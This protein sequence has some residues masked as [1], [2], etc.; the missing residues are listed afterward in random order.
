MKRALA[1]TALAL[2]GLAPA[3]GAAC[4]Y[5]DAS[6]ASASEQLGMAPVPPASKAPAPVVAK[7]SA[8]KTSGV[9]TKVKAPLT[10]AKLVAVK[11]N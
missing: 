4:E 6:A 3:I 1:A 9:Q 7:A 10:D 5:N 2:F 11:S 8:A